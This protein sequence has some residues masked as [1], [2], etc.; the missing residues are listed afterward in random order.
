M[1][2]DRCPMSGFDTNGLKLW[3]LLADSVNYLLLR[4]CPENMTTLINISEEIYISRL[5]WR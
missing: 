5:P 3:V 4:I 1:V 2:E